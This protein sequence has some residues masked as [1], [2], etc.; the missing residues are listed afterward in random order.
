M[1]ASFHNT[2]ADA[3]TV[4]VSMGAA[5]LRLPTRQITLLGQISLSWRLAQPLLITI[6]R[7]DDSYIVSDD[8]F[9]MYGI[10]DDAFAAMLDYVSVLTEYYNLLSSH[11]DEPSV[12]LFRQLQGYLQPTGR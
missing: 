7:G 12:A 6:E 3:A 1:S 5:S 10:G 9:S 2:T 8:V 11:H 4:R